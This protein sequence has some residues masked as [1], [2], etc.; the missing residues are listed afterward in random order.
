MAVE[1]RNRLGAATGL[2]LPA[3]LLFDHPTPAALAH[4]LCDKL[5]Q[6]RDSAQTTRVS[7]I[8]KAE[9]LLYALYEDTKLR[10]KLTARMQAVLTSWQPEMTSNE[11][12]L[13]HKL[14]SATDD[15][16]MNLLDEELAGSQGT[17]E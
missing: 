8:D 6:G 7:D 17:A 3:T 14:R 13:V 16:F 4:V 9:T 15:E 11:V 5:L 10:A 12:D 1:L 2:K